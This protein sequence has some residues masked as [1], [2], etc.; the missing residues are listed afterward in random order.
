MIPLK[1]G[2]RIDDLQ[3]SALGIIQKPAHFCFGTDAVL[4]SGFV[5]AAAKERVADLCTGNG[6]VPLLLSAKTRA[7]EIV[8]VEIQTEIA[9]MAER[10]V[11]MNGLSERV[12]ILCGDLREGIAGVSGSFDVVSCNPPYMA[13]G[14]GEHSQASSRAIARQELCCTLEEVVKETA[15]L[16]KNGG[17]AYFVYRPNR[18]DELF[19][20]CA[21]RGLTPKRMKFAHPFPDREANLVLLEAVK[22]GGH[23]LRVEAPIIVFRAPGVYTDEIREI[24]GY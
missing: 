10:S 20:A 3:R 14:R 6:I 12:R 21:R 16:L 1:P 9:D 22:G 7:K 5:R 2:E 4:L 24:Y 18:L 23:F 15:R 8:A 13:L 19:A 11:A 17:R